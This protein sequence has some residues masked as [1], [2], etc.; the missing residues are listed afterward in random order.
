MTSACS[1]RAAML[2]PR[3]S[4]GMA[5]CDACLCALMALAYGHGGQI[6]GL[7][8]MQAPT[9]AISEIKREGWIF[10]TA[11]DW[12]T[13]PGG[14]RVERQSE[15]EKHLGDLFVAGGAAAA[16]LDI[17]YSNTPR[18]AAACLRFLHTWSGIS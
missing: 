14:I 4:D 12:A 18:P 10:Y 9:G 8:P 15:A 6:V 17:P 5:E 1:A 2:R 11:S 13:L 3:V 16:I 7:P